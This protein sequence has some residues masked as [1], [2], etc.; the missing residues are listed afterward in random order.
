M[1]SEADTREELINPQLVECGWKT[2]GDIIVRREYPIS[3]GRITGLNVRAPKL[4]ADYVLIYKN[5]KLAVVEA[6]KSTRSYT[7]GVAQAKEY[8]ELLN[9]RFTYATNGKEIYQIDMETGKEQQVKAY[10]TPEELWQMTYSQDNELFNI[11]SSIPSKTDG[12]FELRYYQENAINT[13]VK[14]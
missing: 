1:V 2:G 13:V 5:V 12:Q 4:S 7:D 11:L 9:I 8:A 14:A 6:K 10:P 3:K